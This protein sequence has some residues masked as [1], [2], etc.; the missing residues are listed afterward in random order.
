MHSP[1]RLAS[2]LTHALDHEPSRLGGL[3]ADQACDWRDALLALVTIQALHTAP[4][5][6]LD[7]AEWFQHDPH[8]TGLKRDLE[9]RLLTHRR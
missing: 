4:L 5:S 9:A 6:D 7:G 2:A 3:R 1:G 8:V